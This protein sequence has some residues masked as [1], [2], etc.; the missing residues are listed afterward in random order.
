MERHRSRIGTYGRIA[1]WTG[2]A[3][4][5][6]ARSQRSAGSF[7]RLAP[8]PVEGVPLR[9]PRSQ[10]AQRARLPAEDNGVYSKRLHCKMPPHLLGQRLLTGQ[11]R[12]GGC[13]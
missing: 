13:V 6:V 10:R 1:A 3:L 7:G 9:Q 11:I 8:T 4:F 2:V 12:L 5:A